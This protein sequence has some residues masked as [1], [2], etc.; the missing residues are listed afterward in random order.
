MRP[1]KRQHSRKNAR[2]FIQDEAQKRLDETVGSFN[3][4]TLNALDVNKVNIDYYAVHLT[5][6][7]CT[8]EKTEAL[9]EFTETKKGNT[10]P[11]LKTSQESTD[12]TV[13]INLQ[14][15]LFGE[16]AEKNYTDEVLD[17][18]DQEYEVDYNLEGDMNHD[19]QGSVPFEDNLLHGSNTKC[20]I[21]YRRGI[22]PSYTAIGKSRYVL[23]PFDIV[24]IDGYFIDRA[25]SPHTFIKQIDTG[26]TEFTVT[27]PKYFKHVI[28]SVRNNTEELFGCK[29]Y[30]TDGTE[31]T[32]AVLDLYKGQEMTFRVT[33]DE[34]T[35]AVLEFDLGM[36]KVQGNLSGESIALNYRQL[37][38]N[39]TFTVILP[40]TLP[41]VSNEDVLI[42][43]ERS[44]ALKVTNVVPKQT[45]TRKLLEWEAT[46]RVIQPT[47]DVKRIHTGCKL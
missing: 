15:N 47:E 14:D 11:I 28:Y 8:C 26:F 27:V 45:A 16:S 17:V 41:K 6:R 9:P 22:T 39:T 42:I 34:F 35:H 18:I 43:P 7:P 3:D 29:L 44:L 37:D 23:T 31:I 10:A 25:I 19:H 13:N 40:P 21:C 20:G 30:L 32:K 5:G 2:N 36:P 24:N 38:S 46:A 1:H 4:Q 12:E 33:D